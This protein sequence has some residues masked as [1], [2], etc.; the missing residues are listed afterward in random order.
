MTEIKFINNRAN[1]EPDL[2]VSSGNWYLDESGDILFVSC[3]DYGYVF[4]TYFNNDNPCSVQLEDVAVSIV[5]KLNKVSIIVED[6][7]EV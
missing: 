4:C 3:N 1:S 7:V 6:I 5:Q 2:E